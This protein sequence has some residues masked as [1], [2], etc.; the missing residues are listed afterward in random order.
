MAKHLCEVDEKGQLV[1]QRIGVGVQQAGHVVQPAHVLEEPLQ[2]IR[3]LRKSLWKKRGKLDDEKNGKTK[4]M[5]LKKGRV[6]IIINDEKWD[7]KRK[8]LKKEI[9]KENLIYKSIETFIF[10]FFIF[11]VQM[12]EK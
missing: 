4:D 8:E 7:M 1:L 3:C 10:G 5:S 12:E 6:K 9:T 11:Q 2:V